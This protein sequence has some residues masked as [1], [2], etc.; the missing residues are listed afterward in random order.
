MQRLRTAGSSGVNQQGNVQNT[1]KNF[2]PRI[3]V[4]YLA[5]PKTVIR[6]GYGR[7]F[8][9]GYG[10]SLFGIAATQ[11]PPIAAHFQVRNGS[12]SG[13]VLNNNAHV[14]V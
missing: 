9:V 7:S 12:A 6:A 4:A 3:G 2:G 10:G 14:P 1:Y 11:N 8:D 5:G 13:L